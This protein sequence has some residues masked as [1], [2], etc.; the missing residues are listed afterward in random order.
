MVKWFYRILPGVWRLRVSGPEIGLVG[1]R[2][3][4]CG[5]FGAWGS[6]WFKGCVDCCRDAQI[7]KL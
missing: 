3:L 6:L 7:P 1:C 2:A 5:F 4:R